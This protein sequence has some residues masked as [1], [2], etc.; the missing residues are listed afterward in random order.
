MAIV[1]E[2]GRLF[3]IVN[4]VDLVVVV[5]LLA[6]VAGGLFLV[7]S[8]DETDSEP[9]PEPVETEAILVFSGENP[10]VVEQMEQRGTVLAGKNGFNVTL[11][12][13]YV[14]GNTSGTVDGAFAATIEGN[15]PIQPTE[16]VQLDGEQVSIKTRVVTV[17]DADLDTERTPMSV[18]TRVPAAVAAN[19][20]PGTDLTVADQ[21]VGTVTDVAVLG[22]NGDNTTLHIGVE[23]DTVSLGTQ[24]YVGT[25]PLAVGS[26]LHLSTAE[27]DVTGRISRVGTTDPPDI[28]PTADT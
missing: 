24:R 8:G 26:K 20:N 17:G 1:D 4:I 10:W 14:A 25:T 11:D 2:K 15:R 13:Q 18:T 5:G 12:E 19:V 27:L 7:T 21:Q 28:A 16:T 6:V 22:T 3:G 23:L 9:E